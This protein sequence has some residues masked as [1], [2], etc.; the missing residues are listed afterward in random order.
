MIPLKSLTFAAEFSTSEFLL[1]FYI[2]MSA[3]KTEHGSGGTWMKYAFL[4][5]RECKKAI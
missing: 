5:L 2:Q 1:H 3:E 4:Y